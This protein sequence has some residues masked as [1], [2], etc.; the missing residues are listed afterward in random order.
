MEQKN[1]TKVKIN[2][3]LYYHDLRLIIVKQTKGGINTGISLTGEVHKYDY[4]TVICGRSNR[5]E[6]IIMIKKNLI[7]TFALGL[8][9]SA[10][11]A[12]AA[13]A[14][15]AYA[16]SGGGTSPGLRGTVSS[17]DSA[18][19]EK[20]KEMDHYLFDE[21]V[22]EIEKLNFEIIYTGVADTYVEVGIT[23]Y[24]EENAKYLYDIFGDELVKV[25]DT[26][27]AVLYTSPDEGQ[28]VAIP[29]APDNIAS[30]IMD[31]GDTPVSDTSASDE[32]LIKE[33]EQMANDNDEFS[34]QIESI[35]E[36]EPS[37]DMDPELIWQT[38]VV[39]DLPVSDNADVISDE[40]TDIRIVSDQ[41]DMVK[42]TSAKD[43][44]S[45]NKSLPT[46]SII[47]I[48]AGGIIIIGGIVFVSNKKK[49]VKNNK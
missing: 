9:I 35:E 45:E 20:Q 3:E 30:P 16:Q 32:A 28:N 41:D 13:N 1:R 26:Q 10:L 11:F 6:E 37:E 2:L 21:H 7:K 47:A 8:C 18:L 39:E 5:L 14:G 15:V 27:E 43:I 25:V 24:T 36:D 31:M 42:T 29:V 46:A 23:P 48:V 17:E 4:D 12:G 44:Q 49:A 33:R 22:Q 38:G 34:I 19:F 40:D